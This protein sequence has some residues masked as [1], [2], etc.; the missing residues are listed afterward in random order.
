MRAAAQATGACLFASWHLR[1]APAVAPAK[2][3]LAGRSVRSVAIVW[4]E[5]VRR[6]HPGQDWIWQ[7]GGFGVFDP[8]INALSIL[9]EILPGPFRVDGA[10]LLVPQNR[11]TPIAAR[12]AMTGAEGYPVMC[13]FDWR[14]Q[15]PQRW[16]ISVETDGGRLELSEGG[17]AMRIDGGQAMRAPEREYA[18]VYRRFAELLRA[19]ASEL[20]ASPLTIVADA[21]LLGE[22][23][24][25][26]PFHDPVHPLR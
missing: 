1:F 13:D 3:W 18:G 10:R 11:Q 19:R 8:G 16:E 4:K 22:R 6:W 24:T 21:F 26:E 17:V 9:T 12:L 20:D 7:P 14:E 5:D 15:G 23:E 25:T 2:A